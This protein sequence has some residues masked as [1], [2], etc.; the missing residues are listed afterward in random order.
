MFPEHTHAPLRGSCPQEVYDRRGAVTRGMADQDPAS[1]AGAFF[2]RALTRRPELRVSSP[3]PFPSASCEYAPVDPTPAITV[4]A[5][6]SSTTAKTATRSA[7]LL[8]HIGLTV[9][10]AAA[11]LGAALTEKFKSDTVSAQTKM[12]GGE[13][14]AALLKLYFFMAGN[15]D[16]DRVARERGV[17]VLVAS[18]IPPEA[19]KFWVDEVMKLLK[20]VVG[21]QL[22]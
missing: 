2:F 13:T 21:D 22:N 12:I 6:S 20:K 1:P 19:A 14:I 4:P 5:L 16:F 3:S 15:F 10:A 9:A 11:A 17:E 7:R 8:E 18:D